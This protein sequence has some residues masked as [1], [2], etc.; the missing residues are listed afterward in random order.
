MLNIFVF[1]RLIK[2]DL[3][4]VGDFDLLFTQIQQFIDLCSTEQLQIV[5]EKCEYVMLNLSHKNRSSITLL[6]L[7][8]WE[9]AQ[10]KLSC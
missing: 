9:I 3:P 2:I 4:N 7:V 8:V 10:Q 5:I 6:H 1:S